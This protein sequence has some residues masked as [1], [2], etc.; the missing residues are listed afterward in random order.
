M[1]YFNPFLI[2]RSIKENVETDRLKSEIF[3]ATN[4]VRDIQFNRKLYV[5]N[6]VEHFRI[7]LG[8]E[9]LENSIDRKVSHL[10]SHSLKSYNLLT[11][12]LLIFLSIAAIFIGLTQIVDSLF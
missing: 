1:S 12:I 6:L 11:N 4:R 5:K 8:T 10:Q 2:V 7:F 9:V 3:L